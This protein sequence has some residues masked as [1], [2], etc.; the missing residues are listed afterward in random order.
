MN[1]TIP[2]KNDKDAQ[3][4]Y[5]KTALADVSKMLVDNCYSHDYNDYD[6][7]YE[8]EVDCIESKDLVR[9]TDFIDKRLNDVTY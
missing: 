7:D 3:I 6:Y 4:V 5:L 9:I 8:V 2:D 1:L